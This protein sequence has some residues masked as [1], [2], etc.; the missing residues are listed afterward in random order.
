A[1]ALYKAEID[2]N[3]FDGVAWSQYGYCLH[4]V[5][6]YDEALKAFAKA[7]E[8]G[9][10][11]PGNL[12]NSACSLALSGKK[13]EALAMLGRAL[14]ARFAEQET[15][16]NDTDMDPLRGEMKF[17]ELTGITKGLKEK[18]AMGREAGWAW[19]LDFYARRMKQMHWDLYGKVTREA[20]LGEIDKL[21][22]EAGSLSDSQVRA[23]L[24]K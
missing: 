4:G 2:A 13:E 22:R 19:D 23:R 16:E 7:I 3:P 24:K 10:N 9:V 18:P 14:D 21:K 8:L 12:Y 20:F 5:K 17:A 1:A 15:L 6:K 11:K